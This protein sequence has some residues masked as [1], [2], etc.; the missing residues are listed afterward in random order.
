MDYNSI[1]DIPTLELV[2]ALNWNPSLQ[3][4]SKAYRHDFES[5]LSA[6]VDNQD[7]S[8]T[9]KKVFFHLRSSGFK[10]DEAI[11]AMSLRNVDANNYRSL[12]RLIQAQGYQVLRITADHLSTAN[13]DMPILEVNSQVAE[14]A[15]WSFIANSSFLVGTQSG[16]SHFSAMTNFS[17]LLTNYVSLPFERSLSKFHLVCTKNIYPQSA[18]TLCKDRLIELLIEPWVLSSES[19]M[20]YVTITEN[21]EQ[22]LAKA[23]EEF[24]LICNGEDGTHCTFHKILDE[25]KMTHLKDRYPNWNIFSESAGQIRFLI[26]ATM[27]L[28]LQDERG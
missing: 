15:Q 17:C 6:R 8:T 5:W 1:L 16:I 7:A 25:C 27:R 10:G 2:S 4:V 19:L 11:P 21:T 23:F 12:S 3:W 24:T 28:V 26:Q 14:T 20:K 22:Q 9:N 18:N 13:L